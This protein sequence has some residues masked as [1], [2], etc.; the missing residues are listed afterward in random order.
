MEHDELS[1]LRHQ[2][3]LKEKAL[4]EMTLN[5]DLQTSLRREME[6]IWQAAKYK[7]RA[8]AALKMK[9]HADFQA[10]IHHII[11]LKMKHEDEVALLK[12]ESRIKD[13]TIGQLQ[14]SLKLVEK[15]LAQARAHLESRGQAS[16]SEAATLQVCS[17]DINQQSLTVLKTLSAELKQGLVASSQTVLPAPARVETSPILPLEAS[18]LEDL[19]IPEE[20]EEERAASPPPAKR[21]RLQRKRKRVIPAV[22]ASPLPPPTG[23]LSLVASQS[24]KAKVVTPDLETTLEPEAFSAGLSAIQYATNLHREHEVLKALLHEL[25]LPLTPRDPLNQT[26]GDLAGYLRSIGESAESAQSIAHATFD[27]I[28]TLEAPLKTSESEL[29]SEGECRRSIMA[30]LDEEDA[31]LTTLSS[32]L[33]I[34]QETQEALQKDLEDVQAQLTSNADREKAIQSKWDASQATI[35]S[36]QVDLLRAQENASQGQKDLSLIR[37]D[38]EKTRAELVD[39]RAGEAGRLRAYRI[40]YVTSPFFLRKMGGLMNLMLYY[41][42]TGRARQLFEQGLLHSAPSENFLDTARL[43]REL[44][45]GS[46]PSFKDDDDIFLLLAPSANAKP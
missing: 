36:L 33:K 44:P 16:G 45:A 29:A 24:S 8:K 4:H 22:Q 35:K 14:N 26:P 15:E 31:K 27:K 19:A 37:A 1:S 25:E 41:G 39:Y 42:A 40:S 18:P 28:K 32:K 11:Y 23:Q 6:E 13:E 5:R 30:E 34:L 9:A 20:I 38:A 2:L 17:S 21:L 12:E 7:T 46:Y 3:A 43:M 10:L